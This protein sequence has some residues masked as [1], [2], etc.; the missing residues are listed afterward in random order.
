MSKPVLLIDGDILV[1]RAGFAVQSHAQCG[2]DGEVH[3]PPTSHALQAVRMMISNLLNKCEHSS[4]R[5]FITSD[6]GSNF[7]F[8][9]AKTRPYKGNRTQDKPVYYQDIRSF[10]ETQFPT[11]VVYGQEAD[12]ALG[13]AATELESQGK[14]GTIITLDKD[15]DMIPGWHYN[16]VKDKHYWV[17]RTVAYRKFCTQM[18]TG[19]PVDNIIGVYGIGPVKAKAIVGKCGRDKRKML[20]AV[21][22]TY[23]SEDL[24]LEH[25]Q[26]IWIRRKEGEVWQPNIEDLRSNKQVLSTAGG[27]DLKKT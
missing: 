15:L 7:R 26:L 19:D 20:Q 4:Y 24:F 12:D 2:P 17:S 3:F 11:T 9:A 21:Y 5:V 1:Y 10:L 14:S 25:G 8:K 13:I 22:D 27:Q 6:D 23:E 16:F 18:L